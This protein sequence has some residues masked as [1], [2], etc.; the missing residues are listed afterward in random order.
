MDEVAAQAGLTRITA[1]RYFQ[2]R[3]ELVRAAFWQIIVALEQTLAEIEATGETSIEAHLTALVE[4]LSGLGQGDLPTRLE[5]LSHLY[6]DL[7]AEFHQARRAAIQR[8]FEH[9]FAAAERQ[10]RLRPGL[11]R[12]V[13]QAYFSTAVVNVLADPQLIASGL[14]PAEIFDT[15]KSIFLNGILI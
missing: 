2:D 9:L 15:V 7:Y 12:A 4:R 8:I 11:N 10:G 3:Q 14:A 5:E 1:Y 13:I 6:P